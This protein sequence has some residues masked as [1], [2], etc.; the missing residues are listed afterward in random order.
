MA[1][2]PSRAEYARLEL[3][4][5]LAYWRLYHSYGARKRV[6]AAVWQYRITHKL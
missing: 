5:A 4:A 3:K 6:I 1:Q 2:I